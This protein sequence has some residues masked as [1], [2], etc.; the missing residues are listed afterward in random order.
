MFLVDLVKQGSYNQKDDLSEIF[1]PARLPVE[2]RQKFKEKKQ[3]RIFEYY[4]KLDRI[5]DKCWDTV[6]NYS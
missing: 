2:E 4:F 5:K 3:Q 1:D 6:S